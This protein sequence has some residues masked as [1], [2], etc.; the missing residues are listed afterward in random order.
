MKHYLGF[1]GGGTKTE[2]VVLDAVGRVVAQAVAGPSNPLRVGSAEAFA[3]L[4]VAA[5]QAL[6]SVNLTTRDVG[7]VCAGLAGAGRPSVVQ[8][9]M[10]YLEQNFPDSIA[11]VATDFEVA[12]EA[13]AGPGPGAVLIA[14]TGSSAYGRNPAGES[15]RAGG[16]GPWIGDEG[17]AFD[18]GR[19]AVVAMACAKDLGS[20]TPLLAKLIPE[21]L[22]IARWEDLAERIAANPD[23][24]FPPLFPVVVEAADQGDEAAR[25][26]L[27]SAAAE[28]ADLAATVI[29]RLGLEKVEFPLAKSGGVFGRSAL[30][31]EPLDK[32]LR[33]IAPSARIALLGVSPAVGAA[34]L[35]RRLPGAMSSAAAYGAHS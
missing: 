17:S 13:A 33:Q 2:C 22:G 9:V 1:D 11:H 28:L 10:E 20:P 16:H 27:T 21:A 25:E 12:L 32:A 5:A 34:Q 19:R 26:I 8:E 31:D 14:G 15:A 35:A 23:E 29:L 3:A 18:I 4:T 6:A 7:A 30:L 24:V